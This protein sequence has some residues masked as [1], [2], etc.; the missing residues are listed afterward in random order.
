M[1]TAG[2]HILTTGQAARLCSVTPDT[3]LKWIKSGRLEAHRTAG[4]HYRIKR[5]HLSD[6]ELV[7]PR[8]R[9]FSYCWEFYSSDGSIQAKCK[10]CVV[11][12]TRAYRC[13]E[14]AKL[15]SDVGHQ[16]L[17]CKQSCDECD[18]FQRVHRQPTNVLVVSDNQVLTA[19][20]ARDADTISMNLKV[21]ECEYTS[22]AIVETFRP[23][24]AIIDCSMGPERSGDL[25]SHLKE[26]PRL[27]YVRVI[28]A[29]NRGE[30]PTNCDKEVFARLETPFDIRDIAECIE[31]VR[32]D[33]EE[34]GQ[35]TRTKT[36]EVKRPP[37]SA[38]EMR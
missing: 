17:F 25:V 24:Y 16:K 10:N 4:G 34:P 30:F 31:G 27:P 26:D 14:V 5:R 9:N 32:E 13:Y 23:D 7:P 35:G 2:R 6:L 28:L 22:S 38:E 37:S 29:G 8:P 12:R 3:I 20:L 1:N 19:A 21:T 15:A 18:Y 33:S 11:Y 36:R